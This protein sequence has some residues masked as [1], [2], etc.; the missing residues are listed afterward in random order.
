M[1]TL[2]KTMEAHKSRQ[3]RTSDENTFQKKKQLEAALEGAWLAV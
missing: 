1:S 3:R 2:R